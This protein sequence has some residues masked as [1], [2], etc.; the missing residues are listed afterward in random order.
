MSRNNKK[1]KKWETLLL[2]IGLI[3]ILSGCKK[4]VDNPTGLAD[5]DGNVY[6][7][8]TIGTQ[9]WM[10]ENL[11]AKSYSNGDPIGTTT[12]ATKDIYTENTPEYQWAYSGNESNVAVNGRLYTW[13]AVNDSRNICPTGWHVPTYSELEMMVAYIGGEIMAG[14]KLRETGT[15]HWL[16]PNDLTTNE[17]CFSGIGAGQRHLSGSDIF[18]NIG[19]GGYWWTSTECTSSSAWNFLLSNSSASLTIQNLNSKADGNSVRCIKN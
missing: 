8:I 13:Y 16:S 17:T 18:C 12:P 2:G 4:S 14:A 3:L 1:T 6:K 10:A 5:F 7:T 11:K 15:S 9:E 19:Q